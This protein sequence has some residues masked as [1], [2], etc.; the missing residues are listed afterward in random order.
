MQRSFARAFTLPSENSDFNRKSTRTVDGV[1]RYR[2]ARGEAIARRLTIAAHSCGSLVALGMADMMRECSSPS[3]VWTA[4]DL[5]NADGEAFDGV[6]T[7]AACGSR[8][9]PSCSADLR[10]R[11]R[12][13]A[14][15]ALAGFSLRAGELYRFVG[16]TTPTVS[17]ASLTDSLRAVQRAWSLLRKRKFWLSCVRGGIKGVE[18][19]VTTHGYHSHI[20]LLV[21]SKWIEHATLRAEWSHCL[22]VAW[23]E[24]GHGIVFNTPTGEAIVDVRLIRAK[25]RG[26]SRVAVSIDHALQE[27]S[28]YVCKSESWDA[29]PDDHLVAVA[30]VQRW[31]RLFEV[32]G[33]M[34]ARVGEIAVAQSERAT[35][36]LDTQD[37]SDGNLSDGAQLRIPYPEQPIKRRNARAPTL[38]TLM[39]DLDRQAWLKILAAR[40]SDRRAHRR[41]SLSLRYPCARFRSLS[42]DVFVGTALRSSLAA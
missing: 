34:R 35:T 1:A 21:A 26:S 23:S 39:V 40:I 6:G 16:L 38:R 8:L 4:T 3:N 42:G 2:S 37:L 5:H 32:F 13:R 14:R 20:H 18:F 36:F 15:M 25:H 27:V 30:E 9:C 19:T 29:V 11:S 10:R 28:K 33:E 41:T 22:R 17:D 12:R 31:Q 7:L 24:Q